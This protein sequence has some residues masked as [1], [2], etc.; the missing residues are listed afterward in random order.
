MRLF[1]RQAASLAN[2]WQLVASAIGL[3]ALYFDT[4]CVAFVDV[5]PA[6]EY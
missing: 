5:V 3:L 4:I 1:L 6:N 2:N